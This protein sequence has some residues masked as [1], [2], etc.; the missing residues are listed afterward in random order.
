MITVMFQLYHISC[1][2]LEVF[3][4]LHYINLTGRQDL[5]QTCLV[6]M[7]E[8]LYLCVCSEMAPTDRTS[9]GFA[10]WDGWGRSRAFIL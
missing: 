9:D 7:Q 10:S 1:K 5:C 2:L 8:M 3:V 6:F 4:F